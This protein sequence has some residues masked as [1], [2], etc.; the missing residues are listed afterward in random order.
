ML[1]LSQHDKAPKQPRL[2]GLHSDPAV[3]VWHDDNQVTTRQALARASLSG[4]DGSPV[5]GDS[6][7][8]SA[9]A[10]DADAS[11]D[12]GGGGAAGAWAPV[13]GPAPPPLPGLEWA[14]THIEAGTLRG[15][16][17]SFYRLVLSDEVRAPGPDGV[18]AEATVYG[19]NFL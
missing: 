12:D 13:A 18:C 1:A 10:S 16:P 8:A 2:T 11:T 6:D 5:P 19:L 15:D 14:G 17:Q 4:D 9:A 7:A 3:F